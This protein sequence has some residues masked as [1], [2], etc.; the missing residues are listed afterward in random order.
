MYICVYIYLSIS[1]YLKRE[2]Y[3]Y[4]PKKLVTALSAL[5]G[6]VERQQLQKT[7]YLYL[8]ISLS[9]YLS[10]CIYMYIYIWDRASR[11]QP[12]S[13]ARAAAG[14]PRAVVAPVQP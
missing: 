13:W 9:I 8:S 1:V 5:G 6:A 11:S 12:D 10:I 7:E 14:S 2:I 3:I 4:G